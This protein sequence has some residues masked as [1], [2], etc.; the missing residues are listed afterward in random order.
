MKATYY[1]AGTYIYDDKSGITANLSD[2]T[3]A[4]I[5]NMNITDAATQSRLLGNLRALRELMFG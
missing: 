5:M 3:N 4:E 2:L 1:S